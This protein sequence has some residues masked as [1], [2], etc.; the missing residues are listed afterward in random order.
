MLCSVHSVHIYV[1]FLIAV[2]KVGVV[3]QS[4][5]LGKKIIEKNEENER[6]IDVWIIFVKCFLKDQPQI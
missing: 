6:K 2:E 4:Q 1:H 5:G 3:S